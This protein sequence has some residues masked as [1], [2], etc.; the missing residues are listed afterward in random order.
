MRID[1]AVNP[2]ITVL[3]SLYR[4]EAY[5]EK[6][7]RNFLSQSWMDK[8]ELVVIHNDPS[9]YEIA[10]LEKYRKEI[11]YL[12]LERKRETM[13]ASLNAGIL[14]SS[15]KYITTWNVDDIRTPLSLE[16]LASGLEN[17]P[18]IGWSYGDFG[19]TKTYG[20]EITQYIKP[21]QWSFLDGTSGSIGGPFFMFR[22]ELINKV[23]LFDEQFYSGGDFDYTVRLSL[24]SPG[25]KVD[26]LLGYFLHEGKGLSTAGNLQAVERTAIQIRYGIWREFDLTMLSSAIQYRV[27][28]V[29][30]SG[31]WI[32]MQSWIP[33]LRQILNERNFSLIDSLLYSL[34]EIARRLIKGMIMYSIIKK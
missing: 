5:L 14:A 11:N 1:A 13:Y 22:R 15:G 18:S 28:L 16:L 29:L 10:I 27:D 25:L 3:L 30:N 21:P 4:G 24:L 6:Y 7:L 23:G 9:K 31:N 34:K 33:N 8:A 20:G 2:L 32:D 26:G 17:S 12:Y 19:V